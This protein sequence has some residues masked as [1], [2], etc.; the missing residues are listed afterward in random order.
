MHLTRLSPPEREI[1]ARLKKK[2]GLAVREGDCRGVYVRVVAGLQKGLEDHGGQAHSRN[3]SLNCMQ[4]RPPA[5]RSVVG[6]GPVAVM[7]HIRACQG[8]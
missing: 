5:F 6:G 4:D 1:R 3:S 7:Q 2:D 8:T